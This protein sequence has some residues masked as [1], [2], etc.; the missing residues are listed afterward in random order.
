MPETVTEKGSMPIAINGLGLQLAL[1]R[2]KQE[3]SQPQ[4]QGLCQALSLGCCKVLMMIRYKSLSPVGSQL[5]Y[6]I[7]MFLRRNSKEF[8]GLSFFKKRGGST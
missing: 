4:K 3:G 6:L 8:I 2:G 5:L 7:R 1:T